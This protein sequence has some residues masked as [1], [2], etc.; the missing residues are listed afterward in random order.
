MAS[1]LDSVA[2]QNS[3]VPVCRRDL[4]FQP[5]DQGGYIVKDLQD[6]RL[7]KLGELEQFLLSRLD[8]VKS[9]DA[10]RA[11][12]EKTFHS[13][14]SHE[15][16]LE[17]IELAANKGL[18]SFVAVPERTSVRSKES[19][20]VGQ[21]STAAE[22]PPKESEARTKEVVEVQSK[23][24]LV[25]APASNGATRIKP[26]QSWL[27]WRVKLIDPNRTLNWLE[28]RLRLLWSRGFKVVSALFIAA[29]VITLALH[30]G[31]LSTAVV[32]HASWTS[33]L[34]VT[35]TLVGITAI[36]EFGHGLTCKHH[37]GDVH[38]MGLLFMYF[39]PCLY[40]N[41]SDAWMISSKWK[42]I[43][44]TL[45]GGY[46]EACIWAL[47]VFIWRITLPG[48]WVSSLALSVITVSGFRIFFNFNPLIKLDGYY[49]LS[50]LTGINHLRT[51]A[52]QSFS[53]NMRHYLWGAPKPPSR[54]YQG[55]VLLY[56]AACWCFSIGATSAML[57]FVG[58]S[59]SGTVGPMGWIVAGGLGIVAVSAL[60]RGLF[61]GE[62]SA[63][64]KTRHVRTATMLAG[65][66]ALGAALALVKMEQ[67]VYGTF[68][69]SSAQRQE[70]RA[71][72]AGFLRSI[73][74]KQGDEI[75]QGQPI[76]IVE[77]PD[78]ESRLK[79]KQ[80]EV[81]EVEAQLK[82]LQTGTRAEEVAAQKDRIQR[83]I[84]WRDLAATTLQRRQNA[85]TEN[86]KRLSHK[87]RQYEAE[88]DQ[89]RLDLQRVAAL[90]K[91]RSAGEQEYLK[92]KKNVEVA[93]E[94]V[95]QTLAE[96]DTAEDVGVLDAERELAR[97]EKELADERG[98]L[99]LLAAGSRTE[100]I[101]A[102]QAKLAR[103]CEEL[104]YLQD[105]AQHQT[106]VASHA[107]IVVTPKVEEMLGQYLSE[108][109]LICTLENVSDIRVEIS[110]PEQSVRLVKDQDQVFLKARA[111]PYE[112]FASRV[113][114]IAPSA[115]ADAT[116]TVSQTSQV[117][118]T[119]YIKSSDQRLRP[120]M[121]G[122][123]R[124]QC[125]PK[126]LGIILY[127]WALSYIR[128]EFWF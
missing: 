25:H 5:Q 57:L 16:L 12:F 114:R 111:L 33:L 112:T 65:V 74:G 86:L 84:Q 58:H 64:V 90:I 87:I 61:A 66:V 124:I 3:G 51:V 8:G 15:E 29:A 19:A 126:P 56:G 42:R 108:G 121:T 118:V 38:E 107:G 85:S 31:E 44:V 109:G 77:V 78:L 83:A 60:V 127:D 45:A 128:T 68:V 9:S 24:P 14:L 81:R 70:I 34:L 13:P 20:N 110:L 104:H 59:L 99:D 120:G 67:R 11:E 106:I 62:L 21:Q 72:V 103:L 17:F 52:L 92:A 73:G 63:M 79:R 46:I 76:A 71:P 43:G 35:I 55:L 93:T 113:D 7:L 18:V 95:K 97:C 54:D 123:A 39:M 101:E 28:P 100:E 41:V 80:A 98:T 32:D 22:A 53:A 69:I 105:Q 116:E 122:Y 89:A 75:R 23:E 1:A 26:R 102:E 30:A 37:G 27:Y 91:Q 48:T 47:A 4:M 49:I 88:R 40:C 6:G 119:T 115:T 36:H 82:L 50:D 2:P 96:R 10:I 125:D 94:L 117:L